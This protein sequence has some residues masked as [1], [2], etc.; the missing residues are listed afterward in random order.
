VGPTSTEQGESG[1]MNTTSYI[2]SPSFKIEKDESGDVVLTITDDTDP[3]S[4]IIIHTGS[5][6][7]GAEELADALDT[8]ND[9]MRDIITNWEDSPDE[10]DGYISFYN[11]K[12]CVSLSGN[13]VGQYPSRDIAEYELAKAVIE[14]GYY[15]N[16]WLE[17]ERGGHDLLDLSRFTDEQD[18]LKPLEGVQYGAGDDVTVSE[19][20]S[21]WSSWVVDGDYGTLG[22]LL[23]IDGDPSVT[24]FV[25]HEDREFVSADTEEEDPSWTAADAEAGYCTTEHPCPVRAMQGPGECEHTN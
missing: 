10:E 23:H 14:T 3:S 5:G 6:Y 18:N 1:D 11:G 21:D 4:E 15:P 13:Q 7:T 17:G 16:C 2:G 22:L 20:L 9:D 24:L 8:L 19:P 25:E 12:Y